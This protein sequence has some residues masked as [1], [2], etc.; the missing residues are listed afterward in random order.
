MDLLLYS[1]AGVVDRAAPARLAL[2]RLHE[3]GFEARMDESALARH[4]RFAGSDEVRLAAVHR[5]ARAARR[6]AWERRRAV[7]PAA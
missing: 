4:Q 2:R 3:L 5:V 7:R 6:A 1:P